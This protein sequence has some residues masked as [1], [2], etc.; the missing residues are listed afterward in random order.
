MSF[1]LLVEG[2]QDPYWTV[3]LEVID[4]AEE[5]EELHGDMKEVVDNIRKQIQQAKRSQWIRR[6]HMA[7][8]IIRHEALGG[9]HNNIGHTC[10]LILLCIVKMKMK[11]QRKLN[12]EWQNPTK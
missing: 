9:K 4:K 10:L 6:S 11:P 3:K 1:Y 8:D 5:I 12:L 2:K 7:K